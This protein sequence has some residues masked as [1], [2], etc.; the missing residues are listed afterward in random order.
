MTP[1]PLRTIEEIFRGALDQEPERI[2]AF[3]DTACEGDE[4]LR[5][6]V[7]ALIASGEGQAALLKRPL[8][9]WQRRSLKKRKRTCSSVGFRPLQDLQADRHRRD[10]QVYLATDMT[11]GRKAA[12]KLPAD[13]LH[14]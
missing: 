10:G 13:T 4:L 11:A 2:G 1:A 7:E 9:V 3:L 6:K 5:R 12:L 8:L 14:R